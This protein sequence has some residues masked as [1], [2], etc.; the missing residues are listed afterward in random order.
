MAIS[1]SDSEILEARN[2]LATTEGIFTCPEGA[3]T[4]A[5]LLKLKMDDLIKPDEKIVIFNTASGLKYL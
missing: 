1:V 4:Y 5:A 2:K 3:A